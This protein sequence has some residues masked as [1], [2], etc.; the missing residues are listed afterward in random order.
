MKL[1]IEC[2]MSAK[3]IRICSDDEAEFQDARVLLEICVKQH[4]K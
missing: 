2:D 4:V 3:E 1:C